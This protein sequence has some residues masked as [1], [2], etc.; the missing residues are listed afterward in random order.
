MSKVSKGLIILLSDGTNKINFPFSLWVF[1][2]ILWWPGFVYFG[3]SCKAERKANRSNDTEMLTNGGHGDGLIFWMMPAGQDCKKWEN[4]K[5]PNLQ[6]YSVN[7]CLSHTSLQTELEWKVYF[8][9]QVRLCYKWAVN[10]L[11]WERNLVFS[12]GVQYCFTVLLR[13]KTKSWLQWDQKTKS[14]GNYS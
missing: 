13:K 1:K 4:F 14:K 10:I 11:H 7:K 8:S 5:P 3:K 12:L 9:F 6:I 2:C